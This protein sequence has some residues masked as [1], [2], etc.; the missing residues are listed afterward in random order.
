MPRTAP[1]RILPRDLPNVLLP[2]RT[3]ALERALSS[4]YAYVPPRAEELTLVGARWCDAQG[5]E[6]AQLEPGKQQA[7][8]VTQT[9]TV[10]RF[11]LSDPEGW[12][13]RA[14]GFPL[15]LCPTAEAARAIRASVEVLPDG[16]VVCHQFQRRIAEMLPRLLDPAKVGT[17][18]K[19]IV[20]LATR[21]EAWLAH[22]I[23]ATKL[24][25]AFLPMVEH[26][27]RR[28]NVDPA[29]H[30]GGSL[31]GWQEFADKP[32]R[33]GRWDRL[34]AI[35]GLYAEH[36]TTMAAAPSTCPRGAA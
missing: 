8:P 23:R 10:W 36:P 24:M 22:P 35:Q 28:Q 20:P 11:D 3:T 7:I 27:L 13:L 31:D 9:E 1:P 4:L 21:K 25:Q 15:I 5:K 34:K 12:Q 16:T 26:W 33:E 17:A 32:G 29:S 19:L 6:L 30:W 18:E 14:A 2:E